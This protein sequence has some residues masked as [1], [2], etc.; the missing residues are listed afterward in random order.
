MMSTI[1]GEVSQSSQVTGTGQQLVTV[2]VGIIGG[3][4]SSTVTGSSGS[5][6]TSGSWGKR[7][8]GQVDGSEGS[9]VG[10]VLLLF[11]VDEVFL[12]WGLDNIDVDRFNLDWA[13]VV[14]DDDLAQNDCWGLV[15]DNWGGLNN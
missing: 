5:T 6:I 15:H 4:S 9:G 12:C 3:G 8:R 13:G 7:A 14:L 1:A 2:V 11:L 10:G